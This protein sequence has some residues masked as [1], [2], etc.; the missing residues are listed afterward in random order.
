MTTTFPSARERSIEQN[1]SEQNELVSQNIPHSLVFEL[2][3]GIKAKYRERNLERSEIEDQQVNQVVKFAK[4]AVEYTKSL[5]RRLVP[6]F[7]HTRALF[8]L[9]RA[10]GCLGDISSFSRS[11]GISESVLREAVKEYCSKYYSNNNE[12]TKE[13]GEILANTLKKNLAL[14]ESRSLLSDKE[15][16]VNPEVKDFDAQQALNKSRL[17]IANAVGSFGLKAVLPIPIASFVSSTATEMVGEYLAQ[18]TKKYEWID[19]IDVEVLSYNLNQT[20]VYI[21]NKSDFSTTLEVLRSNLVSLLSEP[22]T[23]DHRSKL[24][25]L[26]KVVVECYNYA[27]DDTQQHLD[28]TLVNGRDTVGVKDVISDIQAFNKNSDPNEGGKNREQAKLIKVVTNREMWRRI[29]TRALLTTASWFAIDGIGESLYGQQPQLDQNALTQIQPTDVSGYSNNM[30]AISQGLKEGNLIDMVTRHIQ[31]VN[32]FD[33]IA[34]NP[35][36]TLAHIITNSPTGTS[37]VDAIRQWAEINGANPALNANLE[38]IQHIFG[39]MNATD[40]VRLTPDQAGAIGGLLGEGGREVFFDSLVDP[41]SLQGN[42]NIGFEA[43]AKND[44]VAQAVIPVAGVVGGLGARRVLQGESSKDN[45]KTSR[46]STKLEKAK[47]TASGLVPSA[48][49]LGVAGPFGALVAPTL[50]NQKAREKVSNYALNGVE[51]VMAYSASTLSNIS[52]TYQSFQASEITP[53][54]IPQTRAVI[55]N[56][57]GNLKTLFSNIIQSVKAPFIRNNQED[58]RIRVDGASSPFRSGTNSIRN[59]IMSWVSQLQPQS[60]SGNFRNL[61]MNFLSDPRN[62]ASTMATPKSILQRVRSKV[63]S[64]FARQEVFVSKGFEE[65]FE[66]AFNRGIKDTSIQSQLTPKIALIN[67]ALQSLGYL[68]TETRLNKFDFVDAI[69]RRGLLEKKDTQELKRLLKQMKRLGIISNSTSVK[70]IIRGLASKLYDEKPSNVS[71]ITPAQ[72]T[73]DSPVEP[74]QSS[75]LVPALGSA[76][77]PAIEEVDTSIGG[78]LGA[79]SQIKDISPEE[80]TRKAKELERHFRSLFEKN[81]EKQGI[82]PKVLQNVR[83]T[84]NSEDR[85]LMKRVLFEDYNAHLTA[86]ARMYSIVFSHSLG[87]QNLQNSPDIFIVHAVVLTNILRTINGLDIDSILNSS[88][89]DNVSDIVSF[90]NSIKDKGFD[91]LIEYFDTTQGK[92]E[93]KRVIL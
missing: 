16:V 83:N 48:I 50:A 56:N 57:N 66:Y 91:D 63:D 49:G 9:E 68:K 25:S 32:G 34:L 93:A 45:N 40:L 67:E 84:L 39:Q 79:D 85:K 35:N 89:E 2:I 75:P 18:N 20:R 41:S 62:P 11:N 71:Q 80:R 13:I 1:T 51:A 15:G 10:T 24:N 60:T 36:S 26:F 86:C 43:L 65:V 82:T 7:G 23:Y 64:F 55:M 59:R 3:Q 19:S 69:L 12:I 53:R 88:G 81:I 33:Q 30:S 47:K 37:A 87:E 17:L 77:S 52:N 70:E 76:Q 42:G 6:D 14:Q 61:D 5:G 28:H 38:S 22:L 78:E 90:L 92:G 73:P 74:P 31:S 54:V 46:S 8:E 21:R 29:G 72:Q 44:L 58:S 4:G 27:N